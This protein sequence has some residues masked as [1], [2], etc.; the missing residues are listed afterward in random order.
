MQTCLLFKLSALDISRI[1]KEP[2]TLA[3][4]EVL[5]VGDCFTEIGSSGS[6]G[7]LPITLTEPWVQRYQGIVTLTRDNVENL[8]PNWEG[9]DFV[10]FDSFN[11]EDLDE[12]FVS[13]GRRANWQGTKD[14]NDGYFI[15]YL[16]FA[17]NELFHT[18]GGS[19][20]SVCKC[21]SI[22]RWYAK[23]QPK[24]NAKANGA[25]ITHSIRVDR[26][27]RMITEAI[28]LFRKQDKRITKAAVSRAVG[29]SREHINRR[30]NHLFV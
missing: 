21:T 17:E 30:Y 19:S 26:T 3:C 2:F 9:R 29:I 8:Y 6:A 24:A 11:S 22:K 28:E 4:G 15:A 16:R 12:G 14:A 23:A 13:N 20:S 1:R 25:Y 27:E 5:E 7:Y 18:R 10:L